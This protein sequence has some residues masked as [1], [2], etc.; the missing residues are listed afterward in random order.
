MLSLQIKQFAESRSGFS[1]KN[2]EIKNKGVVREAYSSTIRRR[3][4]KKK[5]KIATSTNDQRGSTALRTH[6]ELACVC[7]CVCVCV[8]LFFFFAQIL[9]VALRQQQLNMLVTPI[10]PNTLKIKTE[11][12]KKRRKK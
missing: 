1:A 4:K 3:R 9:V 6:G 11:E 2:K 12:K 5:S 8:C 7:V 10:K